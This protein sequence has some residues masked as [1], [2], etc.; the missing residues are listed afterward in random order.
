[1]K[2]KKDFKLIDLL[3]IVIMIVL[4]ITILPKIEYKY[5]L[6][7]VYLIGLIYPLNGLILGR[8]S[9]RP[10]VL[11]GKKARLFSLLILIILLSLIVFEL[12]KFYNI[13]KPQ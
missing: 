5:M 12:L 8:I 13:F 3:H 1:M 2:E 9:L 11:H 6:L 7:A 4:F 10:L